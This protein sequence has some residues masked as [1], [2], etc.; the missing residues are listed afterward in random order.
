MK[1]ISIVN[2]TTILAIV[3]ARPDF[4]A[5]KQYIQRQDDATPTYVSLLPT[6]STTDTNVV[7]AYNRYAQ[8]CGP[9]YDKVI[10]DMLEEYNSQKFHP[11][12]VNLTDPN[13]PD[14]VGWANSDPV[15]YQ[16]KMKCQGAAFA[17]DE[18]VTL[19]TRSS[20][21]LPTASPMNNSSREPGG[22]STAPPT[23]TSSTGGAA[24][25]DSPLRLLVL[26]V[27]IIVVKM[28]V[29]EFTECIKEQPG[30]VVEPLKRWVDGVSKIEPWETES[31]VE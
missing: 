13:N 23:P 2:A 18:A 21:T 31:S 30:S 3:A 11:G 27:G 15:Y 29:L 25:A 1:L 4:R 5:P 20:T 7:S 9:T 16:A 6:P 14:F 12:F 28:L 10:A 22:T 24:V 8:D 19:A 17:Y 26:F